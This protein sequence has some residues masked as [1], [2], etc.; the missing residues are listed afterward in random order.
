MRDAVALL[1]FGDFQDCGLASVWDSDPGD[2]F[3]LI[4]VWKFAS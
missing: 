2:D 4:A 3:G 1:D